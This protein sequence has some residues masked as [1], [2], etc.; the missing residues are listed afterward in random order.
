MKY[1][2]QDNYPPKETC[3]CGVKSLFM[4]HLSHIKD[5]FYLKFG[6]GAESAPLS[7]DRQ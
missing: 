7:E 5:W 3:E 2:W 6:G 4:L 1:I